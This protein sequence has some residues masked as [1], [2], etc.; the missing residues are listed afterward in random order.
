MARRRRLANP[1]RFDSPTISKC[2]DEMDDLIPR[3]VFDVC[4]NAAANDFGVFQP[5]P[6][7]IRIEGFK[8]VLRLAPIKK[9]AR[10][11]ELLEKE[12]QW[13]VWVDRKTGLKW[14]IFPRWGDEQT[15]GNPSLNRDPTPP[16]RILAKC[17]RKTRE[18][19][20]RYSHM[21]RET[22][23]G[24]SLLQEG[25]GGSIGQEGGEGVQG[26]GESL[27]PEWAD[28]LAQL[29]SVPGYGGDSA[30]D[31]PLL[32]RAVGLYGRDLVM[33]VIAAWVTRRMDEPLMPTSKPR[34]QLWNWFRKQ[35][36]WDDEA[37]AK[38]DGKPKQSAAKGW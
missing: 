22:L 7:V 24:R 38:R 35:K 36:E 1:E 23:A 30:K 33:R 2:C 5:D 32:E 27:P 3:D 29:Y 4:W 18:F 15:A 34:N 26:E 10:A 28:M 13:L 12:G 16:K 31:V 20:A 21:L 19:F 6:E 8:R 14:A 11:M 17:S 37:A 25:G 9:V